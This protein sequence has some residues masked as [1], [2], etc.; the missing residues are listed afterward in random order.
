MPCLSHPV[1]PKFHFTHSNIVIRVLRVN[2]KMISGR[3]WVGTVG[4]ALHRTCSYLLR[5]FSSPIHT[6][7][8]L[9]KYMGQNIGLFS[10][11]FH[12]F[13]HCQLP[14]INHFRWS[15]RRRE[16]VHNEEGAREREL[17]LKWAESGGNKLKT[18]KVSTSFVLAAKKKSC[19]FS[20]EIVLKS[21]LFSNSTRF[22]DT[23]PKSCL[24][25]SNPT[26]QYTRY[27]PFV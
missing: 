25:Y 22:A 6:V 9:N 13:P 20:C 5:G 10:L 23:N 7:F 12:S 11:A 27:N 3:R 24:A 4:S 8:L 18:R 14:V 16:S 1:F 15:A 19:Q 17:V 26:L 21:S 2:D